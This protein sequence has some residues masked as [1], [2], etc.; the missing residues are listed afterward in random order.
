MRSS[1][2]FHSMMKSAECLTK[3]T[4]YKSANCFDEEDAFFYDVDRSGCKRKHK[5][6]TTFHLFLERVWIRMESIRIID[7]YP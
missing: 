3:H 6:S 4:P 2:L 5:S 1:L 7:Y